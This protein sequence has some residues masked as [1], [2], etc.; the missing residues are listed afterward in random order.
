MIVLK[1]EVDEMNFEKFKVIRGEGTY[2]IVEEVLIILN[3][4]EE[5]FY[6]DFSG[7]IR[8]DKRLRD[9]LYVY[10]GTFEE[11]LKNLVYQKI[12]YKG[13]IE[14][15]KIDARNIVFFEPSSKYGINFYKYSIIDF[16]SLIRIIKHFS[17]VLSIKDQDK[18][19]LK[20]LES[21]RLLRNKVMHHSVVFI[22][23]LS[24]KSINDI[25]KHM[26]IIFN[27]ISSLHD[28][29]PIDWRNGFKHE[30][31]KLKFDRDKMILTNYY[32]EL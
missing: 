17:T 25:K 9:F 26:E 6:H 21:I 31:N 11:Y 30:L 18:D 19:F 5:V 29:L 27:W 20:K 2:R 1:N 23:P 13:S 7:F 8:Y 28:L 15:K 24:Y 32:V 14:I 4:K 16:G 3:Q 10:L 22:N 12:E